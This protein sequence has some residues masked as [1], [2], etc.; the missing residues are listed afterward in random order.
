MAFVAEKNEDKPVRV[1]VAIIR[2]TT[3]RM[4]FSRMLTFLL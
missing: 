4:I 3:M 2:G 1:S